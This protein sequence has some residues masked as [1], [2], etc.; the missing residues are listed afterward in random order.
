MHYDSFTF[1]GLLSALAVVV[2]IVRLMA[3]DSELPQRI[4]LHRDSVADDG[5]RLARP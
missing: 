1:L 3:R 4:S 5:N 2:F